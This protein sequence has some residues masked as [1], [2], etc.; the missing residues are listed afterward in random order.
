MNEIVDQHIL[1][2]LSDTPL[3]SFKYLIL[4]RNKLTNHLKISSIV[5]IHANK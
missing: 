2:Y 3:R 1:E 5:C 4:I